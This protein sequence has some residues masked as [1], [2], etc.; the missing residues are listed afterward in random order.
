LAARPP[1]SAAEAPRKRT[2]LLARGDVVDSPVTDGERPAL[3]R[4]RRQLQQQR[5][6][7]LGGG[8][9]S[10][11]LSQPSASLSTQLR[12]LLHL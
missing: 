8:G 7:G 5:R 9:G 11:Q 12:D 1:T 10:S 4:Q 3:Q 2:R 6:Q